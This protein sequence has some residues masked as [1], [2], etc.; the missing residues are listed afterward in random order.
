MKLKIQIKDPTIR[1]ATQDEKIAWFHLAMAESV[2]NN[3]NCACE[4]CIFT[5]ICEQTR[6]M[7]IMCKS[8]LANKE[9]ILSLTEE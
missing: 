4:D 2:C 6:I 8:E 9:V 1:E 5:D 7:D 3:S